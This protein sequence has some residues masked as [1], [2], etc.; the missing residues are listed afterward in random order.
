MSKSLNGSGV[1]SPSPSNASASGAP[2]RKRAADPSKP[3][4]VQQ[5]QRRQPTTNLEILA[6]MR[7][8]EKYLQDKG[9]PCT[10]TEIVNYLSIQNADEVTLRTFAAVMKRNMPDDKIKY[11]PPAT[12]NGEGTYEY[13]PTYPIRN[14]EDLTAYLQNQTHAIGIKVEELK[15]GWKD[16][17]PIID[18]M[19]G[20]GELLVTY[21]KQRKPR[22]IWQD[23]KTLANEIP[24][25]IFAEWHAI[26]IPDDTEELRNKLLAAGQIPS[27]AA[28]KVVAA[29]TGKTKR[30]AARRGGRTTNVHMQGILKDYSNNRK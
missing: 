10:F 2:K 26:R 13:N 27:S 1:P 14:K 21:D 11:N 16:C 29:K 18:N 5:M 28:R 19:G 23:D 7:V 8:A 20:T 30:K 12:S 3:T 9:K 17:A 15:D 4:A 25:D 24:S 22:V 6:Q